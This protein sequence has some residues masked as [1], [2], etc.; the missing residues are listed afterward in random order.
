MMYL[1]RQETASRQ[2]QAERGK[3]G[4]GP[5]HIPLTLHPE[6]PAAVTELQ[7]PYLKMKPSLTAGAVLKYIGRKL[8]GDLKRPARDIH[9]SLSLWCHGVLISPGM[10]IEEMHRDVWAK[11]KAPDEKTMVIKYRVA[12]KVGEVAGVGPGAAGVA[13]PPPASTA[14]EMAA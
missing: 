6:D 2:G 10:T 13:A 8:E 4:A 11:T 7:K 14:A 12:G 3:Q 1:A 5:P 9:P